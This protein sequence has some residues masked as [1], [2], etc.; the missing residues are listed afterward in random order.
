MLGV[1]APL[2][3]GSP[4]PL[5]GAYRSDGRARSAPPRRGPAVTGTGD[6][7]RLIHTFKELLDRVED[8]VLA[9]VAA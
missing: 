5:D 7:A 9:A 4:R 1:N 3:R 2:R 8:D 6:V